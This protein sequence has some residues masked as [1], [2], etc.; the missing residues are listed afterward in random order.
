MALAGKRIFKETYTGGL[1]FHVPG[2]VPVDGSAPINGF[3]LYLADSSTGETSVV[4]PGCLNGF[5]FMVPTSSICEHLLVNDAYIAMHASRVDVV[6]G[7]HMSV[8]SMT[9]CMRWANAADF[10]RE[11]MPQYERLRT[12]LMPMHGLLH[13]YRDT[14]PEALPDFF[15][16]M[17]SV[18]GRR[19]LVSV[20]LEQPDTTAPV[21]EDEF[22]EM[23]DERPRILKCAFCNDCIATLPMRAMDAFVKIGSHYG[24]HPDFVSTFSRILFDRT[25]TSYKLRHGDMFVDINLLN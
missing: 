17:H 11:V 12:D 1:M 21:F 7:E 22:E 24:L 23:Q 13:V 6:S 15:G 9:R 3:Y 5:H 2:T 4:C 25:L 16:Q 19:R 10:G 8:V 20:Y 18:G 14:R